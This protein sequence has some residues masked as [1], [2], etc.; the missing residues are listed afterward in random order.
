M[1]SVADETSEPAPRMTPVQYGRAHINAKFT[2][3]GQLILVLPND[4]RDG[5]KTIIQVRDVQK[6]L[7]RNPE[8]AHT[9]NQ[10]KEYPGPLTMYV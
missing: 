9:V 1:A 7:C 5:E 8:L 2:P 4:P 3:G 10:M 6:M